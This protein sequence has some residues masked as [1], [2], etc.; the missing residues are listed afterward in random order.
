MTTKKTFMA[1]SVYISRMDPSLS[2]VQKFAIL[3]LGLF[4][5]LMGEPI[6]YSYELCQSDIAALFMRNRCKSCKLLMGLA[7]DALSAIHV[8]YAGFSNDTYN[9]G[10]PTQLPYCAVP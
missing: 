5:M 10:A 2:E 8:F 3:P 1:D 9:P 4:R 6:I 7:E